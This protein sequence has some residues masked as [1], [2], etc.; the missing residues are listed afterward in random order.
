MFPSKPPPVTSSNHAP[1]GHAAA[2]SQPNHAIPSWHSKPTPVLILPGSK[3]ASTSSLQR[4]TPKQN[5]S[6][7]ETI[8]PAGH[9]TVG[10]GNAQSF[11]ASKIHAAQWTGTLQPP[12]GVSR[13]LHTSM[14]TNAMNTNAVPR[15]RLGYAGHCLGEEQRNF[16]HQQHG[17]VIGRFPIN[18]EFASAPVIRATRSVLPAGFPVHGYQSEGRRY[19]NGPHTPQATLEVCCIANLA[20][21]APQ[22]PAS[23]RLLPQVP[24]LVRVRHC[25]CSGQDGYSIRR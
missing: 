4:T 3:A 8:V 5:I 2:V 6:N 19:P 23:R 18:S 10:A 20:S 21:Y 16:L 14:H 15:K 25:G 1:V 11:P 7:Y 13:M 22:G 17:M 12:P 24:L 9:S